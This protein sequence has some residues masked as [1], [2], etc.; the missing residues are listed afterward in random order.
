MLRPVTIRGWVQPS[1][2]LRSA[3]APPRIPP[4]VPDLRRAHPRPDPPPTPDFSDPAP[5]SASNPLDETQQQRMAS[6]PSFSDATTSSS[7]ARSRY[8]ARRPSP[9]RSSLAAATGSQDGRHAHLLG[10]AVVGGRLGGRVVPQLV[11]DQ[12]QHPAG[13]DDQVD[14]QRPERGGLVAANG[15]G[16]GQVSGRG[17]WWETGGGA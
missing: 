2:R 9:P 4:R 17:G 14:P 5:P 12:G 10:R 16:S 1:G 8:I 13:D 7:Q 6:I 15:G 11:V 3:G